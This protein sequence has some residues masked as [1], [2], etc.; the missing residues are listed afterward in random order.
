MRA[1]VFEHDLFIYPDNQRETDLVVLFFKERE[2][3]IRK[4]F[5]DLEDPLGPWSE[6][7]IIEAP[8]CAH[9]KNQVE[10]LLS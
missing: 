7:V 6:E 1:E 2:L 9:L 8:N 4:L 5:C 3:M 10:E